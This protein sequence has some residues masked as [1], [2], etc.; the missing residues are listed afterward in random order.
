MAERILEAPAARWWVKTAREP[1]PG[2]LNWAIW[3]GAAGFIAILILS[4]VF[5]P[6]I[7]VLHTFQALMYVAVITLTARGSRWGLYLA[8]SA[9]AFWNYMAMFVNTF[10]RAGVHALSQSIATGQVQHPD[11]VISVFAVSFHFLMIAGALLAYL[12]LSN[13]SW[14]DLGGWL[15]TLVAQ[16]VYFASIVALFQPRYLSQFARIL[17]PHA[18]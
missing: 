12:R 4:A 10:F 6:T 15:I 16:T 7:R 1:N 5:D 18:L 2:F 14:A 3:I 13:K 9:A 11:L 17:H 8:V